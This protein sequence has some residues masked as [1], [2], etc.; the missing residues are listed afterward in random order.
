MKEFDAK[1]ERHSKR[2]GQIFFALAIIFIIMAIIVALFGYI[3][4]P[5]KGK[6]GEMHDWFGRIIDEIPPAMSLILPHWAG[7]IWFIIDC[8]AMLAMVVAIDRFFVKSKNYFT[9]IKNV[10]F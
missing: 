7:H 10:D 6:D 2:M 8:L 1:Q 4:P 9:G 5:L 3:L